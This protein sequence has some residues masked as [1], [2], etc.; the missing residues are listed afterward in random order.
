MDTVTQIVRAVLYEGYILWPYRRSA[1]K[2]R[3]RWTFGGVYPETYSRARSTGDAF[4][5][6]TQCLLETAGDPRLDVCVRFLHVIER[7]VARV[8]DGDLVYVD[9]L[10]VAGERY[11]AWDE[12][13]ER[14]IVASNL[15]PAVL[16]APYRIPVRIPAG[17]DREW[18][19]DTAGARVGALVREWRALEGT[20][21]VRAER[22]APRLFR[23]TVAITNTTPCDEACRDAAVRQAFAST[24]TILRASGGEFVSLMDP[25]DECRPA[26]ESCRNV[27]AWPVLVGDDGDRHVMLSSPVTL[28][29]YP[30][31]A[32]ES[33]GDLFDAT[34][35]DALLILN[36][37]T[38]TDEEQQE[39]RATDPRA[40]E[41]LDRC[42]SLSPDQLRQ[43]YGQIRDFRPIRPAAGGA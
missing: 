4:M 11:L 31:V 28:Y 12:A 22:V 27:G 6:Q 19:A 5:M 26:A 36:V 7:K 40:R 41:I 35:I 25:P 17:G 32:P 29:D 43:L 3:Q 15:D 23:V 10:N 8:Q 2:N 37:L 13:T 18:I 9:E 42:A 38:L 24:H 30:R 16:D 21:E 14:D 1:A 39:M 20:M 34:E 33:P